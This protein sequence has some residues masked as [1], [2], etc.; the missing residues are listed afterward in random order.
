VG[1]GKTPIAV[2]KGDTEGSDYYFAAKGGC[3]AVSHGNMDAG[4][5]IFELDGVR[6]SIN[7]GTQ[8]YMIGEQ[9]FDLCSQGQECER[10]SSPA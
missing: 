6:W 1:K 8:S 7:P 3:G 2:F 10:R 9:G 4:S 5:F